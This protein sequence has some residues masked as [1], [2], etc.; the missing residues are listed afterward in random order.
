MPGKLPLISGRELIKFFSKKFKME[1]TPGG[2]HIKLKGYVKGELKIFPI[3]N[4]KE[5]ARGTLLGIIKEAGLT[6][7]EFIKYWNE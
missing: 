3:P 2:R 5:L 4:H 7:E 6:K 1:S